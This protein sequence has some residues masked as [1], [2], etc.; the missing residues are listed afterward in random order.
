[1]VN[2]CIYRSIRSF[3]KICRTFLIFFLIF[4]FGI[5]LTGCQTVEPEK[6]AYPLVVGIDWREGKYQVCLGMAQ[7]A[8]S[9]GQG[10]Q[11]GEEQQ[12]DD[13]GALMLS[14]DSKEAIQEMYNR[15]RELYLDTGHVQ[16]V[17][18]GKNLLQE[19]ERIRKVLRELERETALGNSAYVFGADDPEKIFKQNGAQVQSL[20]EFLSGIYENRKN[21]GDPMVLADIYREIH[22]RGKIPDIPWIIVAQNQIIVDK[23]E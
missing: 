23:T 16:S 20:G 5:F 21:Q 12:G 2:K 19:E 15:T 14:G 22:N 7:L 13:T 3:D 10:K 11:G 6:R 1:M 17:I 18:F 4:Y 9:T 8:D